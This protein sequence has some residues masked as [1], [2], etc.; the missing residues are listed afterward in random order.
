MSRSTVFQFRAR[1]SIF[2]R[3]DPLTKFAWMLTVSLLAFGAYI[4]WI[5]IAITVMVL[6]TA[7][8]LA[9]ITV[10]EILQGTWPFLF[11]C[12]SFFVIQTLTLPGTTEIFRILGKPIYVESADYALASALRI[13]TIILASLVF[14]LR[15]IP[16]IEE[17]IKIIRSAQ[18]VRG[19]VRQRGMTGRIREAKRYAMP[20]LVGALRRASTMV[21]SMEARG[22]GAYPQRTFVEAP[23]MGFGAQVACGAMLLAVVGWYTALAVGVVHSFYVFA[24]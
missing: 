8:I 4:A 24:P 2:H 1:D 3:A 9:R 20:L 14:V 15:I 12:T 6:A 13:Y 23:H 11:A 18:A 17:E 16:T 19:V 10:R 22:F 7:L 21:M 5:Q